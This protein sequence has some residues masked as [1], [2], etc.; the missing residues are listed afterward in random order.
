MPVVSLLA[1]YLHTQTVHLTDENRERD[2]KERIKVA[3][4]GPTLERLLGYNKCL[5]L[6][7]KKSKKP[8]RCR[9]LLP[10][11]ASSSRSEGKGSLS[12]GTEHKNIAAEER[13]KKG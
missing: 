9:R 11:S 12:Q 8:K 6:E 4:T 1:V 2:V 7:G 13:K 5:L 3:N 10:S